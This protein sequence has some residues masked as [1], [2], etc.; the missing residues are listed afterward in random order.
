MNTYIVETTSGTRVFYSIVKA[1]S[2]E[3]AIRIKA[4]DRSIGS[5]KVTGVTRLIDNPANSPLFGEA[6]RDVKIVPP[7]ITQYKITERR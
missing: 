6:M 1:E 7:T 3:D 4:E 2:A 5:G